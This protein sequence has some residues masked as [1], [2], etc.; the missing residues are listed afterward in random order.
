MDEVKTLIINYKGNNPYI[1]TLKTLVN[2]NEELNDLQIGF[3]KKIL[4]SIAVKKQDRNVLPLPEIKTFEINWEKYKQRMPF[5]FQKEGINWLLNKNYAILADEMG[6]GKSLQ[7]IIASIECDVKK[8]LIVC[9]NSLKLNWK[10]ELEYFVPAEHIT[11]IKKD[12]IKPTKYLIVNYEK[13]KKFS[14]LLIKEKFDLVISDEAHYIKSGFKSLR[15]KYFKVITNKIP[16]IWLLSGTPISNKPIDYFY[17]LKVC[18]HELGRRKDEFGQRYCGGVMTNW[19][20]DLSGASNLKELYFKTQ[21]IILRRLKKKVLELPPKQRV[22]IYFEASEK[23]NREL[24]NFVNA[25][26]SEIYAG[27]DDPESEHYCKNIEQGEK[28]IELAANRMFT[29][30]EK[31]KD[32]SVEELI[33]NCLDTG[34]RIVLFSNYTGVLRA[35]KELFKEE[36]VILDGSVKIEDRQLIIDMFQRNEGPGIILA[37]FKVGSVGINLTSAEVAIINDLPWDPATLAQAEDRIFRIGQTKPVTI[38]FPIYDETIDD[39]M[40]KTIRSKINNIDIAI[41]GKE[42]LTEF[43]KSSVINEVYEQIKSQRI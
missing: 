17:L 16:K 2:N 6:L 23:R 36:A 24:R 5:D 1:Q 33:S 40:F 18:R 38:Y 35:Y 15:G 19:G 14:P 28:F 8:V 26:F 20:W 9:P 10:K 27:I 39:V 12:Y 3:A 32:G 7:A 11:I 37:N 41:D 43:S 13:L 4:T 25:K 34:K 29:A 21:D 22:P 42:G 31:T 30:M